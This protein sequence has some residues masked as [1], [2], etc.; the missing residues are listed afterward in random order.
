MRI[1]VNVL[2]LELLDLAT[3]ADVLNTYDDVIAER[4]AIED[5]T[6]PDETPTT[7][8]R[9]THIGAVYGHAQSADLTQHGAGF[10]FGAASPHDEPI[11]EYY[12]RQ[13]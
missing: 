9:S 3:G 8:T 11:P 7:A 6:E 13:G 1:R 2:G 5:D 12:D 4:D 10:G